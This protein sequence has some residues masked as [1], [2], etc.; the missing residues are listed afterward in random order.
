MRLNFQRLTIDLRSALS[1]RD[2]IVSTCKASN[3]R[4]NRFSRSAFE[5][6]P[7][8]VCEG[9]LQSYLFDNLDYIVFTALKSS[10][11][12]DFQ[13]SEGWVVYIKY[14]AISERSLNISDFQLLRL[15][16]RGGF[17]LVHACKKCT[18]G[19]LYAVKSMS[20][21][22][23]KY[24]QAGNLVRSER[25][26]LL[27][28]ESEF[29][30]RL[31][32]SFSEGDTLNLVLDLM[33]GG[34]LGFHLIERGSF[35]TNMAK[36][37][38]ARTILGIEALHEHGIMYRDLKPD[39]LLMN[40]DGETKISDMG[41]AT[42]I[43][44][45]GHTQTC[46]TRGYWAPEIIE[47]DKDGVKVRYSESID[48]FSLGC[49]LYEFLKGRSPFLTAKAKEWKSHHPSRQS[50]PPV[51]Q[52]L[53]EME[54]EFER[55]IF[56]STVEDLLKGLLQKNGTT[57]LGSGGAHEIK[58][59]PWFDD[60]NWDLLVAGR[61]KPPFIPKKEINS[62]P[63]GVIGEFDETKLNGVLWNEDDE[64]MYLNWSFTRKNTFFTE[65]V[66]FL[67][68]QERWGYWGHSRVKNEEMCCN[69]S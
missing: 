6:H 68:N 12:C 44:P 23:I 36:Y 32:Y 21:I 31:H 62:F 27:T 60:I 18:T 51:D 56:D 30:V 22:R 11:W 42:R 15:L 59:H 43:L 45:G 20:K 41:L 38:A 19:K 14:L 9:A 26:L 54:P 8:D 7:N 5:L 53:L 1:T 3:V 66:E 58:E 39:N 49:C 57:R 13:S 24:M 46:G 64:K 35:S 34:D 47:R 67:L 2:K 33:V 55:E 61:M 4:E 63:K 40:A 10:H 28:I 48:W 16:G 69:L 50:L 65:V 25:N 37:Y 17:G 29:I 52:A